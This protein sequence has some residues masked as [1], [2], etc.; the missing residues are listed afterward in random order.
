MK[1]IALTALAAVALPLSSIPTLASA[2]PAP[3]PQP[4]HRAGE[5]LAALLST[6]PA[7]F[8]AAPSRPS[9]AVMSSVRVIQPVAV[10][11]RPHEIVKPKP[12][13]PKAKTMK[14]PAQR[15]AAKA[16]RT[17]SGASASAAGG[18]TSTIASWYNVRPSACWDKRGRHAFPSGLRLW[19]A[20]KTLPCGTAVAV[21]G[22]SGTMVVRVFDRGPYVAGRSL[23]L[24]A[25]AFRGVC[26]STS[27]GVCRV[28]WR[29]AA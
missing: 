28:S 7:A 17:R 15:V 14:K 9:R 16:S 26:G 19:T 11:I 5:K 23:D 12:V 3:R 6:D 13:K 24:S 10:A 22:P 25:A 27:R 4:D 2:E 18:G 1:K 21:T 20:H 29:V 8:A